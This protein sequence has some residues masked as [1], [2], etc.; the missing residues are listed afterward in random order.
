MTEP[1]PLPPIIEK[2][3]EQLKSLDVV[4]LVNLYG[5]R[6]RIDLTLYSD[7]GRVTKPPSHQTI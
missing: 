7:R 1:Q 3:I 2:W 4:A 6:R 5:D